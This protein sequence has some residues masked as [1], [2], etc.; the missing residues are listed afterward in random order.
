M[1]ATIAVKFQADAAYGPGTIVVFGGS[2]EVTTASGQG[3]STAIAGIVTDSAEQVLNN[4]LTG[5]NVVLVAIAGRI[6]V[7]IEGTVNPGDMI[8]VAPSGR[9]VSATTISNNVWDWTIP[10][11]AI[12]ARAIEGSTTDAGTHLIEVLL[13]NS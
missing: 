1:T 13:T 5:P 2:A 7:D 9:G 3:Q 12:F 6:K 4:S 11:G 10:T 8:M